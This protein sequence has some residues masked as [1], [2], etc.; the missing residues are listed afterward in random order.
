[1]SDVNMPLGE[2]ELQ[3][4]GDYV[5]GHLYRWLSDV[6][7]QVIVGPQ[8]LERLVR[9]EEE[10]KNLRET[11]EIRFQAVDRRFE[12]QQ[13]VM[14]AGF[15]AM[16]KR[17]STVDKR[18][19]AQQAVMKAGF[20]AMDKRFEAID[21]RFEAQ[22]AVMKAGFDAMDERLSAVDKRF[23]AQQASMKV[24]QWIVIVGFV[25]LGTMSSILGL[26]G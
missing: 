4:I 23:D 7:P 11:M 10:L 9:V 18:F 26:A 14:K 2:P 17:F 15:D 1:M 20:D 24:Q 5:R 3:R 16:D 12:A 21:K 6:A 8:F 13:A 19:E 22:Q 25:I